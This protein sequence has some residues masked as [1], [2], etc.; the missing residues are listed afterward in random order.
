[1]DGTY[2]EDL[3]DGMEVLPPGSNRIF[4]ALRMQE[5]GGRVPFLMF[6]DLPLHLCH[7]SV[8]ELGK[9]IAQRVHVYST[10]AVNCWIA[11]ST[12]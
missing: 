4:I 3:K 5:P 7:S 12:D 8:I 2:V 1:V 10:H 9:P 6:D 11:S